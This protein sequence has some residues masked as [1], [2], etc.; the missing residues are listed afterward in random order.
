[1][2]VKELVQLIRINCSITQKTLSEW[3]GIRQ[4]SLSNYEKGK[5]TPNLFT[6]KKL[7]DIANLKAGLF[8][9]IK[10]IED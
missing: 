2:K 3:T 9:N 5:R 1:M 6:K 4:A 8:I 10:D 7:V